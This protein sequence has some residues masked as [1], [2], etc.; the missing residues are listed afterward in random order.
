MNQILDVCESTQKLAHEALAVGNAHLGDWVC[1][2]E[3]TAGRGRRGN[4][5]ISNRGNFFFSIILNEPT[6]SRLTWSAMMGALAVA[7]AL[8]ELP[9][10]L[11]W[12]N[13]LYLIGG[14]CGGVLAERASGVIVL[15][16]GINLIDQPILKDRQ[17]Q[18]LNGIVSVEVLCTR[19]VKELEKLWSE[20]TSQEEKLFDALVKDF[21][22][23]ALF[24]RGD[25][26]HW[27][28]GTKEFEGQMDR[29]GHFGELIVKLPTG[30][31][32]SLYSEDVFGVRASI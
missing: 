16:I 25:A 15:G 4:Q 29:L 10:K 20:F 27:I 31:S 3:Q 8:P 2:L 23:R 26:I 32:K 9:I 18:S 1:S 28:S 11:K 6:Q 12:P 5:W 17:T 7:R 30:I 22:S 13:D 14:K 21:N 19:V 24:S